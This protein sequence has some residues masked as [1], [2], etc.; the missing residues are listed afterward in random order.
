M[1]RDQCACACIQDAWEF[2]RYA[3]RR[4]MQT[5]VSSSV[6]QPVCACVC[7][8]RLGILMSY[9]FTVHPQIRESVGAHVGRPV[10]TRVRLGRWELR[11]LNSGLPVILVTMHTSDDVS[12][13]D[14]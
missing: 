11:T 12:T 9:D 7:P 3:H 14:T 1:W 4:I 13:V 5:S 2:I 6:G 8:G 10:C